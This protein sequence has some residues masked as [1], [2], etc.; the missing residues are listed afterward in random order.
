MWS[1][2]DGLSGVVAGRVD[3]MFRVMP[4]ITVIAS[5]NSSLSVA[6]AVVLAPSPVVAHPARVVAVPHQQHAKSHR[7]VAVAVED[8]FVVR[9][10]VLLVEPRTLLRGV[11]SAEGSR[12]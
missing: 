7:V 4:V 3:G 11:V 12:R 6:V 10:P 8:G 9:L 1:V 2:V 5:A